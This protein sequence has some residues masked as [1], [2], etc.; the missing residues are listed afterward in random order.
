MDVAIG[1]REH[2]LKHVVKLKDTSMQWNL[3]A[4]G[5][6]EGVIEFF[7]LEGKEATKMKGRSKITFSKKSKR[8]NGGRNGR[9]NTTRESPIR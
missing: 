3:I 4:A 8:L 2:R 5:V 9:R 1:K 7:K 6:E